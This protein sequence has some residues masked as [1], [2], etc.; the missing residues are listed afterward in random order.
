MRRALIAPTTTEGDDVAL[1]LKS[2]TYDPIYRITGVPDHDEGHDWHY[3][4]QIDGV[5]RFSD[6]RGTAVFLRLDRLTEIEPGRLAY[7]PPA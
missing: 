2:L 3:I 4:G 7:T 5:A 6:G 1:S